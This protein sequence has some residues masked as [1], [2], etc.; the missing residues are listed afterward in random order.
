MPRSFSGEPGL[1]RTSVPFRTRGTVSRSSPR[2]FARTSR[3]AGALEDVDA[4]R[5]WVD[6]AS[7]VGRRKK[8]KRRSRGGA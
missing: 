4:L 5:V 6:K 7:V 8:G 3:P 2:T 1:E